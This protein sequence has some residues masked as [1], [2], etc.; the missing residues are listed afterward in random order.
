MKVVALIS[1]GKDSTFSM[2]QTIKYGH[3][4]VALANLYPP[5]TKKATVDTD[6]LDSYMFQTVGHSVVEAYEQCLELPLFRRALTGSSKS[7]GLWFY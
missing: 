2:M 5:P 3:T 7:L 6:E 1:G 4:L